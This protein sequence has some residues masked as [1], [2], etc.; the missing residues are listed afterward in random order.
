MYVSILCGVCK[1]RLFLSKPARPIGFVC[2]NSKYNSNGF[3]VHSC[4]IE[5][6]NGTSIS[7]LRV[8]S[9]LA[10]LAVIGGDAVNRTCAI[11]TGNAMHAN[12]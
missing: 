8:T 1:S 9:L 4:I 2:V 11:Q 3:C 5:S 7:A 10:E 12:D 6:M